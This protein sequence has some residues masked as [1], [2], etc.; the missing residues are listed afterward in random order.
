M[1]VAVVIMTVMAM[2]DLD[3]DLG[4]GLRQ[5]AGKKYSCEHKDKVARETCHVSLLDAL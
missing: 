1:A 3:H 4:V 5:A 2:A